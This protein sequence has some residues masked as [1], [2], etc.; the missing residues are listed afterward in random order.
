MRDFKT[1]SSTNSVERTQMLDLMRERVYDHVKQDVVFVVNHFKVMN[2]YAF[3]EATA[4]RKDGKEMDL[5]L[6]LEDVDEMLYH[7]DRM[8]TALRRAGMFKNIRGLIL[9]G[10][11]QM[12]DNTEEFGFS[13]N[14]PWGKSVEQMILEMGINAET[15][16]AVAFP[17]GHLN[18]NRAFYMG[19]NSELIVNENSAQLTWK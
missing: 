9:G 6:F 12:R 3:F 10:F 7:V 11:T 17:A 8:L 1:K 14:N 18:D 19:L 15:P 5:T 13:S 16:I 4:Q 2:N